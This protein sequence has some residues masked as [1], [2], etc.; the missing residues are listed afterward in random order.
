MT[1]ASHESWGRLK[2]TQRV[3]IPFGSKLVSHPDKTF[4]PF[5]MGRSYGDSCHNDDG[6]LLTNRRNKRSLKFN[7]ETGILRAQ[8]GILLSEITDAVL[9]H[10]WFLPVTPGTQ[11]VTLGGAI[12]NDV[13]GKN[14]HCKGTFGQ[15]VIKFEL[16]RSDLGTM[17]CSPS[18]NVELFNATIAGM[19]LT[20]MIAWAEIQLM[21]VGSADIDQT[22]V[23]LNNLGDFFEQIEEA[24]R[25][26]EYCVAWIDSLARG[27][28]LGRGHLLLGNH[29]NNANFKPV[30]PS[31]RISVPFTPPFPLVSGLALRAFNQ[32]YFHKLRMPVHRAR[33]PYQSYFYPLDGI[34]N[35]NRL[36]GPRG[37]FQHQCALP[38]QGAERVVTQLIEASHEA[39]QGSFLTVLKRFGSLPSPGLMSFPQP[40]Y[41]LTLDFANLGKPTL[42]LMARLDEIT[43]SAGG[44]VNP[45]KDA[46]MSANTFKTSFPKWAKLEEF[47]DP[48]L[49]SDFWNR[50]M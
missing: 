22:R 26:N 9:P 21:R 20:G 12:A 29:A 1:V 8:S 44:R 19:G 48:I 33:V 3:S 35:W 27:N 34:G 47:R 31:A 18:E 25:N 24:D 11:F 45:Y 28:K 2:K 15:H 17:V 43:L 32:L 30:T 16:A 10:G 13:H 7:S 23:R 14:H 41:T 50:V 39:K 4:L 5:G 46:R 38:E 40:G 36:Y 6:I 49:N 42:E 37:L